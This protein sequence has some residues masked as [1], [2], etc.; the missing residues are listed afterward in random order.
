MY[1]LFALSFHAI[2]AVQPPANYPVQVI[3]MGNTK[4]SVS[5]ASG[6]TPSGPSWFVTN[7]PID[8]QKFSAQMLA[9]GKRSEPTPTGFRPIEVPSNLFKV[10]PK[11]PQGSAFWY[12]KSFIAP[13]NPRATLALRMG[14]I[15]DTDEVY[16]NGILIGQSGDATQKHAHAWDKIRVYD[17]PMVLLQPLEKNILLVRVKSYFPNEFGIISDHLEMGDAAKLNRELI[18]NDVQQLIFLACYLTFGAYFLFLFIR[19]PQDR[20]YLL[21]FVFI[22]I[23][24]VYQFLQTQAKYTVTTNFLLLKRLEYLVLLSMF[25]AFYFYAREFFSVKEIR[26]FRYIHYAALTALAAHVGLAFVVLFVDDPAL[27]ATLNEHIVLQGT[28]P[29]FLVISLTIVGY[30]IVKRDRD[31]T[32]IMVGLIF[33]L[34]SLIVDNL[35]YYGILNIPRI[36]SYVIFLFLVSLAF[37]LANQFVRVHKQVEDLNRNLEQKVKERTHELQNSLQHVQ[38]LKTQQDGDYFLTSLLIEPLAANR[39]DSAHTRVEF[40]VKE[41]KEFSFRRWSREIGGDMCVA[42]SLELRGRKFTVVMNGDAMGKSM[43]GAGGALVLGSVFASI[44]ERTR[45]SPLGYSLAPETWL[46]E[47]FVELNRVFESFDGSMLVSIVLAA[48]DDEAGVMYYI[49]AEHPWTILYRE[50]RAI[51]TEA[52]LALRKL[53][54]LGVNDAIQVKTF[55]LEDGDIVIMGSDGRDDL[56]LGIDHEGERIINEDETQILRLVEKTGGDLAA[57]VAE[58]KNIGDLSDDL[59]L[60]RITYSAPQHR[61]QPIRDI[62]GQAI[63]IL[64]SDLKDLP[65]PLTRKEIDTIMARHNDNASTMH[66]AIRWLFQI[67]QFALGAMWAERFVVEF[68][69]ESEFLY[70]AAFGYKMAGDYAKAHDFAQ[71]LYARNLQHERN[72][73]NMVD[74]LLL[75]EQVDEA[76]NVLAV[77]LKYYPHNA[78]IVRLKKAIEEARPRLTA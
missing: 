25:P 3:D 76:E 22:A 47:A 74:L 60:I 5:I 77:L 73:V 41:K 45:N 26:L 17:I 59:S 27:W 38:E 62:A 20:S 8:P 32:T 29:F 33:L 2:F 39:V 69:M 50:S 70:L 67:K 30:K 10:Y 12:Y 52:E 19:R 11:T 61:K 56:I 34:G 36:T 31:A 72:L 1:I 18:V 23:L 49:N 53:G 7:Q 43:Q 48:I 78:K 21:F 44:I 35:I 75:L 55:Y 15:S 65:K 46:K 14:R 57:L 71:R 68:P 40:F 9:A 51:F 28:M 13:S 58:L 16:L 66:H 4:E 63:E 37:I 54:T 64:K 42:H 6:K 24:V